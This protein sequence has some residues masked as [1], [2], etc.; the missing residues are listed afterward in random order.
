MQI[1]NR[2]S[3]S[4]CVN[5]NARQ[6]ISI[7]KIGHFFKT[8]CFYGKIKPSF[9]P[10]PQ[11]KD[12]IKSLIPPPKKKKKKKKKIFKCTYYFNNYFSAPGRSAQLRV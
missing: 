4:L 6:I 10:V 12:G 11:I 2:P 1:I 9:N 7:S 3:V 8:I 5:R